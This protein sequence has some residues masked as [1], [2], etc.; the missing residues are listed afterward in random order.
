MDIETFSLEGKALNQ[1]VELENGD[2]L[3]EG[4]AADFT[5]LDRQSENF[6]DGAFARGIKSFLGSSASLCFHH[7]HEKVLGKVLDLREVPG[8]G[9]WMRARVD[10][11]IRNH[12]ELGTIYRQIKNGTL[13][14]LSIGGFFK[15]KLTDAGTKI[16][17]IDFTEISI[18]PVAIHPRTRF[19]VVGA[20]A[21]QLEAIERERHDLEWLRDELI[22]A[23]QRRRLELIDLQ[24]ELFSLFHTK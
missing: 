6:T 1:P 10:G 12:P 20:K 13:S 24:C 8:K 3:I 23:E 2:L 5:G 15:R 21:L 9:L 4:M 16:C 11:A 17:D 22:R 18:T 7:R 14:G 19:A